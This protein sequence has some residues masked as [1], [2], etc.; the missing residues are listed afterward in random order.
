MRS[1]TGFTSRT[2]QIRRTGAEYLKPTVMTEEQSTK[3]SP[4]E[5]NKR[6]VCFFMVYYKRPELTRMSMYHMA[7]IIKKFTDAGHPSVGI[8]VGDEPQQKS[9][10]ESLGLEHHSQPNLPL[11]DK[12]ASAFQEALKTDSDYVCWL[13]SNNIHSEEYLDKCIVS[14]EGEAVPSFGTNRFTVLSTDKKNQE[15]CVFTCRR[16]HLVS[17][18]QFYFSISLKKAV[19]FSTVYGHEQTLNFDGKVNAAMVKKW[20]E[21]VLHK[22]SCEPEDCLDIKDGT[23]MH[24]YDSYISL[25]HYPRHIYRDELYTKYEELQ[26]LE[27]GD[28]A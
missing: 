12:F 18:G 11:R 7:K 20:D 3:T 13:G 17:A 2:F 26:M 16:Y 15:T 21:S 14:L 1:R 28:F 19:N 5:K 25:K 4:M 22:A 8:V 9:Y 23:D 10:A 27:R 6:T 24:S